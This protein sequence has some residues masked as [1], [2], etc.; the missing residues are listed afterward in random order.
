MKNLELYYQL[1]IHEA[2][3]LV[4]DTGVLDAH[5]FTIGFAKLMFNIGFQLSG[6]SPAAITGV[7]GSSIT[8]YSS[9]SLLSNAGSGTSTY[10]IMVGSGT[11]AE[12]I[13]DTALAT[14][15]AHGTSAGQL[16]Y[17]AMTYGAPSTTSTT[18]TFR[19]TRVFTNASGN[20]VTVEEIGLV[21]GSGSPILVARD[22]TGT[23]TITN[24]Q[25]LTV[26][27]DFTTTI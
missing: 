13:S 1:Q 22:L 26:N 2:D 12:G 6:A 25:Q 21:F 16:Q 14:K 7:S 17:G 11:T 5:S 18:T 23:I 3:K 15:I 27:Y 20:T 10:G 24:G 19:F 9:M 8:T 4:S